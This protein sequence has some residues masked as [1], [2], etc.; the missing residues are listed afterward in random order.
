MSYRV[1]VDFDLDDVACLPG[2]IRYAIESQERH[3]RVG[4]HAYTAEATQYARRYLEQLR[5][6]LAAIEAR[7]PRAQA[8]GE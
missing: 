7:L 6:C 8:Q 1:N 3:M 2:A 5:N 4:G